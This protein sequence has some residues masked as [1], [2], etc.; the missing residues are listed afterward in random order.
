[1]EGYIS[2]EVVTFCS[3]YLDDI[4][5]IWNRPRR[6]DDEGGI[7]QHPNDRIAEFFPCVGK[8][9]GGFTWF[10]LTSTQRM[11]AHRHILVNCPAVDPYVQ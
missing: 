1:M 4:E 6:V 8:P 10:T 7:S 9:I 3:R 2:Q 11:Q 5:T